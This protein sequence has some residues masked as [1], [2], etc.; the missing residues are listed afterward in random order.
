[1]VKPQSRFLFASKHPEETLERDE[2]AVPRGF[3]EADDSLEDIA[4]VHDTLNHIK[5]RFI[6]T[7][8]NLRPHR[9]ERVGDREIVLDLVG[10]VSN[11]EQESENSQNENSPG[12]PP[13]DG[14]EV[15]RVEL[16]Q[17]TPE[18]PQFL[19]TIPTFLSNTVHIGV[20]S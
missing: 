16:S 13:H 7:Q 8:E 14:V 2:D 3:E 6:Y 11:H 18:T 12:K 17:A 10:G 4:T 15:T 5:H 9:D 19:H 1:M 20:T